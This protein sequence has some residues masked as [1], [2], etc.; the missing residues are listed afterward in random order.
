MGASAREPEHLV[1][2]DV[3]LDLVVRGVED[4]GSVV[5]AGEA[6]V[7]KSV[8]MDAA[9]AQLAVRGFVVAR[10]AAFDGLRSLPLA[11]L[12][13]LLPPVSVAEP[14]TAV[15]LA[16]EALTSLAPGSGAVLC[17]DDA[18]LL[19]PLSAHVVLLARETGRLR[20]VATARATHDLPD[21]VAA[22]ARGSAV[23]LDLQRFARD[24]TGRLAA[25]ILGGPLDTASV[26]RVHR[27]TDG[28]P[29]AVD[30]LVRCAAARR[31]F[32]SEAGLWRWRHDVS[33]DERLASVLGVRVDGVTGAERDAL[34]LV[35]LAES[36][37]AAVVRSVVGTID[38]TAMADRRLLR[39]GDRPGWLLPGHLLLQ[40]AVIARLDPVR[41]TDLLARLV[42]HLHR[43]HVVDPVLRRR[44]VVA[45]VALDVAVPD[46][47]LLDIVR[48]ARTENTTRHVRAVIERAWRQVPSA[49]TG[50]A[51]GEVLASAGEHTAACA[52]LTA[53][54][55]LAA[56]DGERVSIA[57]AHAS[58]LR[59]GFGRLGDGAAILD[60]ARAAT[61]D[62]ALHLEVTAVEADDLL[63][64]GRAAAVI[65]LWESA[66]GHGDPT[67]A[68]YRLTQPAVAAYAYAGR[69]A[70]AQE[71]MAL[72]AAWSPQHGAAHPLVREFTGRRWASTAI[73]A[74][75]GG[76]VRDRVIEQYEAALEAADGFL[77]L[78]SSLPLGMDAW[79]QGDLVRAEHLAR[80]A[81][82][83][84]VD[85]VR[86]IA[87]Y[88]LVR[89]LDLRGDAAGIGAQVADALARTA[90]SIQ[91]DVSWMAMARA[92]QLAASGRTRESVA[93]MLAGAEHTVQLGQLVP[94]TYFFHDVLR[95]EGPRR[96]EPRLRDLARRCDAPAVALMS[97]HATALLDED[98]PALVASA[99]RAIDAGCGTFARLMLQDAV[100][101][102]SRSGRGALAADSAARLAEVA[103]RQTGWSAGAV[104]PPAALGLTPRELEVARLAAGG[105]TDAEIAAHFVVSVRTV[106]AQLR[107][108]YRKLGVDGRRALRGVAGLQPDR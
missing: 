107:A 85:E 96:V 39:A 95:V 63:L 90:G 101:A 104:P 33:F 84:P 91:I 83:V 47:D 105:A 78:M 66:L 21:H 34:A 38:L 82:G 10:C 13:H 60:Q 24:E 75:A 43:E 88:L 92:Q 36:L 89:V 80:E 32:V 41:R 17:I 98:A 62:P 55:P 100:D 59:H 106:N 27:A 5:I 64:L 86:Q 3:E 12:A 19:D 14:A 69:I 81:M 94:A 67:P 72:H 15:Q 99:E 51:F 9:A 45:A 18:P 2:R 40:D 87:Q 48:W 102:A 23:R 79:L 22:L 61:T 25:S 58:S 74:G 108:V 16:V 44:M 93:A 71:V 56:D 68:H 37:P 52:V 6:G 97:A 57:L 103:A 42:D 35:C 8:L 1:G 30:E 77:R 4:A 54:A 53:A 50:H 76:L 11:A 73:L 29:L 7:G 31:A 70:A 26:S 20:L 49:F 28:L 65:E 46:D